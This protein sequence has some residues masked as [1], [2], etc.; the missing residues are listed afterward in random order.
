VDY[1]LP[2]WIHLLNRFL[3]VTHRFDCLPHQANHLVYC[4]I[5]V[6]HLQ[7]HFHRPLVYWEY[8][9][10]L[11]AHLK[12]N[13]SLMRNQFE[14]HFKLKNHQSFIPL[15]NCFNLANRHPRV[16]HLILFLTQVFEANLATL[17]LHQEFVLL[18]VSL[19][20]RFV[21]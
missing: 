2:I 12:V 3:M 16:T 4:L 7:C 19:M 21:Q 6:T 9:F 18:R 20:N 10:S 5:I 14:Y 13:P 15:L 1:A 11:R 17:V 8:H